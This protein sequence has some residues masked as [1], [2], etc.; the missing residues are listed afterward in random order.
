LVAVIGAAVAALLVALAAMGLARLVV[1]P[2]PV[3]TDVDDGRHEP[4]DV[5]EP[6]AERWLVEK[7][8]RVRGVRHVVA[9]L[10]RFV[11]GG[12]MVALGLFAVL[13][14]AALVGWLLSTVDSDRGFARFDESAAEWGASH[15]TEASTTTLRW[16]THFGGT[17]VLIPVMAV[18]GLVVA[19]R[20]RRHD[21][22]R[23]A[24]L[25]FLLTA[26]VGIVIVN[27]VLKW[28]VDRD[29]PAVEH[30]SSAGG[31][32][33][34]SGHSAAAAACWAAIALVAARRL[35]AG[36]RRWA[37]AGAVAIAVAVASS[38]VLL[39]VHWLTDVIA[40]VIVGWTWFFVVALVFGG[41]LQRFGHPAVEVAQQASSTAGTP[42]GTP[43]GAT[44]GATTGTPTA[45]QD[46]H[47]S[48]IRI[49]EQDRTTSHEQEAIA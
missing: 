17:A 20:H 4:L 10:D 22:P 29:R 47:G 31:S 33:F 6:A 15:A 3:S 46:E 13:G 2:E 30:L 12:A 40:G 32:S 35:P 8:L 45:A 26:G 39:G 27:N 1:H 36:R 21:H 11:W 23:W 16:I 25:G 49:P 43:T 9:T 38:R 41:R 7:L 5:A 24:V 44:S 42:T 28:L 48:P 14:G 19:F 37:A 34:P 18:V